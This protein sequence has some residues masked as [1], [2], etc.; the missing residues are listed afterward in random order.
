M[1]I[2]GPVAGSYPAFFLSAFQPV[3]VLKGKL[4]EG[5]KGSW[6]RSALVVFQ[7][8]ISIVL[9]IGT[10]VIYNQLNYIRTKDIGFNRNQVLVINNT[11][12]LRNKAATFRNGL[13]QITGVQ[14]ATMTGYLPT[15]YDA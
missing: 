15:D 11:D 2:V 12:A 4:A 14:D 8:V 7:F 9:I 3:D 6:F 5:F 13:L 1:L 10:V